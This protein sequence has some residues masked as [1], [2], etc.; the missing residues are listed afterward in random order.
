MSERWVGMV[1]SGDKVTIVDAEIPDTGPLV[2]QSDVTWKLQDGDRPEAY[3]VLSQQCVNYLRENGIDK[4]LVKASATSRAGVRLG[5]FHSAEL[6]GATQAAAASVCKVKTMS[7]A[8]LS[9]NFG[10]RKVDEYTKDDGYWDQ[11]F[12][13]E[14]LR[15]GSREAAIMLLAERG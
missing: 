10:D 11:H 8:V 5:H 9:R 4:V 1:V 7:K 15:V 2:L 3:N 6:R 13:G 12:D 14:P